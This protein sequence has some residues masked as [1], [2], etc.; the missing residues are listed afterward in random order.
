[1]GQVLEKLSG[2]FGMDETKT[3]DDKQKTSSGN[4]VLN[5]IKSE[6]ISPDNLSSQAVETPPDD[7]FSSQKQIWKSVFTALKRVCQENEKVLTSI[8]KWRDEIKKDRKRLIETSHDEFRR[9]MKNIDTSIEMI[10]T[11]LLIRDIATTE[12]LPFEQEERQK[13]KILRQQLKK[14]IKQGRQGYK[15]QQQSNGIHNFQ[16]LLIDSGF[17]DILNVKQSQLVGKTQQQK[18]KIEQLR[19]RYDQLTTGIGCLERQKA[20][21]LVMKGD[22]QRYEKKIEYLAVLTDVSDETQMKSKY[23]KIMRDQTFPQQDK[24]AVRF[25]YQTLYDYIHST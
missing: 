13:L 17:Y 10:D 21:F 15:S 5:P 18:K 9:M 3:S 6:Q 23:Q 2:I 4:S 22:L 12:T 11:V 1:M 19:R 8:V 7:P 14:R 25:A 24:K 20:K 16:Q